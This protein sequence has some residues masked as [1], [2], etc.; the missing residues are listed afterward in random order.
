MSYTQ[1]FFKGCLL[2]VVRRS[3]LAS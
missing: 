2:D 1:L 3:L